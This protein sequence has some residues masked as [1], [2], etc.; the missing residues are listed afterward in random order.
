[1]ESFADKYKRQSRFELCS[2]I[3]AH[4]KKDGLMFIHPTQNRSLTPRE[5]ARV[6]SF[7]DTFQFFGQRGNVYEQVGNAVPPLAGRAIGLAIKAYLKNYASS[8]TRP[9]L[10]ES[11]RNKAIKKLEG[12]TNSYISVS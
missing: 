11:E 9:K 12:L 5:A 3:V 10:R 1:M 7:P 6:Q 8:E 2:T 4:L